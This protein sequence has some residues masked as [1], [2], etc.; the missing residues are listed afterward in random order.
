MKQEL[1]NWIK[2]LQVRIPELNNQ[3]NEFWIRQAIEGYSKEIKS[4]SKIKNTLEERK[5]IFALQTKYSELAKD[6]SVEMML[7]FYNYWSEHNEGGKKMRFEMS[8]NQPFNIK[9]RLVTWK[10]RNKTNNNGTTTK[11]S[12]NATADD[13]NAYINS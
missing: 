1:D 5:E 12:R 6:Y 3:T 11:Q 8:K 9:R 13:I 10:Q 7:E 4:L 2:W